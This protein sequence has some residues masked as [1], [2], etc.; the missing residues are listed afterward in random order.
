NGF[1]AMATAAMKLFI[2]QGYGHLVGISSI[3]ALRGNRDSPAYNASK[4]FVSNYLEGLRVKAVRSGLPIY[5]TDIL[6]GFV[7]TA[8]AQGP[9]LFW[10]AMPE[11]AAAQIL[12]AIDKKKRR[13]Y[14][15]R[16]WRLIAWL[17]QVMPDFLYER[18]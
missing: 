16:R 14:I 3:G 11:K 12:V 15:T 7:D 10:V 1:A 18:I 9:G 2:D 13:A 17:M 8:M 5:I 4:A 6:P